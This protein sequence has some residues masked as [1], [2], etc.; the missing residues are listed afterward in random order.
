M[1]T[2]SPP[3]P[4]TSDHQPSRKERFVGCLLGGAVGDAL[5]A[6]VEFLSLSEIRR[7][8]GSAGVSAYTSAYGRRGAITDDTQMTLF[9]AEGLIRVRNRMV[10]R[11]ICNVPAV[12]HR[13]YERWLSTQVGRE[14]VPWDPELGPGDRSGWLVTQAFLHHRRAPGNTCLSAL[15][16]GFR[17]GSPAEPLNSSKGCGG[18]MRVAPVGLVAE[19]PFELGC[20]A[21]ALTH[22]HPSGW[23]AAGALAEMIGVLVRG[24]SLQLAV[25]SAR[26]RLAGHADAGEVSAALAGAVSLAEHDGLAAPE[27]VE[28][29]GEGWVA[30]EALAIAVFCA[31]RATSFAEGVL[32]AVNHGGD[33]D[34]TGS[35]TGNLLGTAMGAGAIDRALLDE[36]EGGDAIERIAVDLYETFVEPSEPDWERYPPW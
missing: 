35:L 29:L 30:E 7:Q 25:A 17:L 34:S 13:A 21:A 32:A 36:L 24:E 20:E 3:E 18:V 8:F 22:G 1:T 11:G 2:E 14:R 16:E 5:G 10:D 19:D 28:S 9:T 6:P 27:Q 33:S 4:S 26:Q 23:L 12:L 31:L 15:Q